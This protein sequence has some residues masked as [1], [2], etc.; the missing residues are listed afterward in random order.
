MTVLTIGNNFVKKIRNMK[1]KIYKIS[2]LTAL[3]IFC[4][5]TVKAQDARS[6]K[7]VLGAGVGFN[8]EV[9]GFNSNLF[10]SRMITPK[11]G[12]GARGF[13][14]PYKYQD[15]VYGTLGWY[16]Q[17]GFRFD[18]SAAVNYYIIGNN[19]SK[20]GLYSGLGIGYGSENFTYLLQSTGSPY[21]NSREYENGFSG[22]A[23]LGLNYKVGPGKIFLEY[24][25][26][27]ILK[28]N[29]G[30]TFEYP[31]GYPTDV[32]GNPSPYVGIDY[33]QKGVSGNYTHHCF[34]LGYQ[35]NF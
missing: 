23:T 25:I 8:G 28:G 26:S 32:D 21:V 35:I 5:V 15:V 31:S 13:V 12:F 24:N 34:N 16:D 19:E 10:Y 22:N 1:K 9:A 30:D 2:L 11:L 14:T 4:L 18:V 7:N 6:K 29:V 3:A 33:L 20:F 27:Y 17:K